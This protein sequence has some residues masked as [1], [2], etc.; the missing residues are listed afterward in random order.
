MC[1][2]C[3]AYDRTA[4]IVPQIVTIYHGLNSARHILGFTSSKDFGKDLVQMVFHML[5][6]IFG[7]PLKRM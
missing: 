2:Y 7:Q 5:Q 3:A 1:R 6:V 4:L